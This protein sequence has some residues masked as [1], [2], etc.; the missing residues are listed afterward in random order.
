MK[1]TEREFYIML[2][3]SLFGP[4]LIVFLVMAHR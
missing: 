1:D 3:S 4:L 2:A